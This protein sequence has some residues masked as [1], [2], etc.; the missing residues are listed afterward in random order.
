MRSL[1]TRF[2]V[3]AFLVVGTGLGLGKLAVDAVIRRVEQDE[4]TDDLTRA[5]LAF[6][7]LTRRA[8]QQVQDYAFWD[9]TVRLAQQPDAPGATGFFRRNLVEWLPRND[10]EFIELL[11][12]HRKNAFAWA[13]SPD[14]QRPE[15]ATSAGFLDSL[16]R[17][18]AVGGF[19][20]ERN[21]LYLVGGAAVHPSQ[22][23]IGHGGA[24]ARGYLVIGR[25]MH[26]DAIAALERELNFRLTVLP[27]ETPLPDTPQHAQTFANEDSLHAYF[28]LPGL[29]GARAAVVRLADSRSELHRISQWTLFGVTGALVFGAGAFFLVWLYGRRL[30]IT[31]LSAIAVEI[32]AMHG[33]GELAEVTSAPPSEEWALF[34]STFNDTVRSLRDSEQRYRALFDRAADPYLLLDA[35]TRRVVDA[36]PAAA[37]LVGEPRER[38]VGAPLPE[39]LRVHP[40][41]GDAI[42][43]RRPDGTVQTWGVLETDITL[44]ERHLVLAAYRDLTDREALAQSQKMDAI[45]SLAG[46]IAHAF[47][48][49]M[50]SVL[51]GVRVA[52]GTLATDARGGAALDAIE[53]AGRRA[54][55]LTRQLLGVSRHEP[56]V[57]VPVDVA[58][59]IGNIERMCTSTF[60]RRI[61]I[62]VDVPPRL[63]AVEGDPGQVEQ[64]LLN[65]CINARDAW[66]GGGTLRLAARGERLDGPSALKN[67]R[68]P[69][70]AVRRPRRGR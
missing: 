36:N 44:G 22:N 43:V 70:R 67:S 27:A 32:V 12:D 47:N 60:D 8:R 38:L 64:A 25:A 30:L 20:R 35:V 41:T 17:A 29:T 5:R 33:R 54:A 34:L 59:A 49:L 1:L 21:R 42:R 39:M 2:S 48:N 53:H 16:S 11:D 65:L 61:R 57:R 68:H 4:L 69:A 46:G 28:A 45:G 13:A 18:G 40:E 66:P 14:V 7:N 55:E 62:I 10:Y 6:D 31:P 3:V 9:E 52:R 26:G 51:A 56:L 37:A 23:E 19:V 63:P 58:A 15:V 50:G 24:Q